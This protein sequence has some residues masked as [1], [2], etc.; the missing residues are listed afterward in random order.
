MSRYQ[1][2]VIGV[3]GGVSGQSDRGPMD[4]GEGTSSPISFGACS[5]SVCWGMRRLF[6]GVGRAVRVPAGWRSEKRGPRCTLL[7][8]KA[9]AGRGAR[10]AQF[11]QCRGVVT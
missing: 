8:G 11:V 6:F 3:R 4:I 7:V 1:G 2:T 10:K 5:S 9:V